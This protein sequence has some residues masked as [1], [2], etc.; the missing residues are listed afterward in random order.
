MSAGVILDVVFL[1]SDRPEG[2]DWQQMQGLQLKG[3]FAKDSK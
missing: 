3:S 2:L 1:V